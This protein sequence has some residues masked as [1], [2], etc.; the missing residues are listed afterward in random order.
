MSKDGD[1]KDKVEGVGGFALLNGTDDGGCL[2]RYERGCVYRTD[3]LRSLY[4]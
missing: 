3:W 2:V 1:I 4:T